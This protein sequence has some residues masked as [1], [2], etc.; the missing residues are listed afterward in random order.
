MRRGRQADCDEAFS[1]TAD[2]TDAVTKS[3]TKVRLAILIA[4]PCRVQIDPITDITINGTDHNPESIYL[5]V[6]SSTQY[7]FLSLGRIT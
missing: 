5:R 6:C 7:G 3:A 2:M 1:A 4:S